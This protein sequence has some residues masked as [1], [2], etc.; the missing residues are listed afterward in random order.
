MTIL[1]AEKHLPTTQS[2]KQTRDGLETDLV[3][4]YTEA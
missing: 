2:F 4:V 3:S 1:H